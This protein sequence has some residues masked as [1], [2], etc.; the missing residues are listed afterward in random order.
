MVVIA[1]IQE[2]LVVWME[3]LDEKT[4]YFVGACV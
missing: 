2:V 1:S 3:G 4:D